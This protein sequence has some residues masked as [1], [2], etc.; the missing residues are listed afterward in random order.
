ME[1]TRASR[2]TGLH[3]AWVEQSNLRRIVMAE[4]IVELKQREIN[5]IPVDSAVESQQFRFS[6]SLHIKIG[7]HKLAEVPQ[8]SSGSDPIFACTGLHS[9]EF[10]YL[11]L[12]AGIEPKGSRFAG[13]LE[14]AGVF[15]HGILRATRWFQGATLSSYSLGTPKPSVWSPSLRIATKAI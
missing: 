9:Q 13:T 5:W 10:V 3:R 4:V 6:S 14:S 7:D 15:S 11:S 2:A 12:G 8:V 1:T